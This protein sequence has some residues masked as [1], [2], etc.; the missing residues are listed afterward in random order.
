MVD[1]GGGAAKFETGCERWER[2]DQGIQSR[3]DERRLLPSLSGLDSIADRY[4]SLKRLGYYWAR[5]G[6]A[7]PCQANV[8]KSKSEARNNFRKSERSE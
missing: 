7:V 3:R 5:F 8:A 2:F 6:S 4:P 1:P